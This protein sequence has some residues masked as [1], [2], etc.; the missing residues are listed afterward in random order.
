MYVSMGK[1]F[2]HTGRERRRPGFYQPGTGSGLYLLKH[3]F[4]YVPTTRVQ[5]TE[6]GAEAYTEPVMYIFTFSIEPN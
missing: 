3:H 5:R 4:P 6:R 1:C 2:Y